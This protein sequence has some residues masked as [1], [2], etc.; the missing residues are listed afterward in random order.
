MAAMDDKVEFL[1]TL[2]EEDLKD[3]PKLKKPII[4][5]YRSDQACCE[6]AVLARM[7]QP[8]ESFLA[9]FAVL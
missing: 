9:Y 3:W 7:R 2:P 8:G 4:T 1:L 5:E 6:K